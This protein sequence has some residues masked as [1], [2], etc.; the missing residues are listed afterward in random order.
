MRIPQILIAVLMVGFL[1]NESMAAACNN[2]L[3]F[4]HRRLASSTEQNLCEAYSGNVIMVVNTASQCGF[5][6]QFEELETL[7]QTYRDQGFVVLGFPS[8]DFRQEMDDEEDTAEVCFVNYGVS[9]PMFAAT[10]VRGN[11]ANALFQALSDAHRA[12]RWNFTKYL[13]DRDGQP[14]EM[15]GS[16]TSPVD[17]A[18]IE[19]VERLLQAEVSS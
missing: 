12:P 15:F 3:D 8:N 19:A 2:L 1:M 10:G 7:Y 14:V 5:T 16:R 13:I 18:V 9:F 11:G 6:P 17:E 4:S